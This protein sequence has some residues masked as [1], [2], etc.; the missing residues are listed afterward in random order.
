M[1]L[2]GVY[3]GTYQ[4]TE[5]VEVSK[6]RLNIG[7]IDDTDNSG[8]NLTGGYLGEID[9]YGGQTLYF[10]S[11]VGLPIGLDDTD[12][13][14]TEQAAYFTSAFAAAE[15]SMYKPTFTDVSA[16]WQGSWDKDSLVNWFLIEELTGH[17]DADHFSSV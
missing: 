3:E 6:A 11:L 17:Q 9:H 8:T 15:T 5:K 4:L 7:S 14:T 13:P 1:Y 12:P 2:N 10:D 16:G